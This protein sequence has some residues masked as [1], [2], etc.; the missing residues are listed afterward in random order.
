MSS[1][2]KRPPAFLSIA[3]RFVVHDMEQALAFYRQLG[4]QT[5]YGNEHFAVLERDG[6][7]LHLNCYADAP[8]RHAVCWI[9][10]TNVDALYQHYAPTN[11]VSS[12]EDTAMGISGIYGEEDPFGNGILFAEH[13]PEEEPRSEQGG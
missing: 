12:L 13:I 11:A 1:P 5:T 10:V 4:F 2:Q 9:G 3:P 8:K 7:N 6:V